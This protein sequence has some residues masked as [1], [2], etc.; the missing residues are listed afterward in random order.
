MPTTPAP[1]TKN[2]PGFQ[3][4]D[5]SWLSCSQIPPG[6]T[7]NMDWPVSAA[8]LGSLDL[9]LHQILWSLYQ[10][11]SAFPSS[12][13]ILLPRSGTETHKRFPGGLS[14]GAARG[15]P[16]NCR[17]WSRS[18]SSP[19]EISGDFSHWKYQRGGRWRKHKSQGLEVFLSFFHKTWVIPLNPMSHPIF[20]WHSVTIPIKSPEKSRWHLGEAHGRAAVDLPQVATDGR[21]A[22]IAFLRELEWVQ[23]IFPLYI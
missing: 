7:S 23:C 4:L 5:F 16:A 14:P 18:S 9:C 11:F 20:S 6:S 21:S 22:G 13:L 17:L 19:P 10:I 1:I 3:M 15:S 2:L 8:N 12:M